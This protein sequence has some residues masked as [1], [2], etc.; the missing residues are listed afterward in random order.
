[1]VVASLVLVGTID[2]ELNDDRIQALARAVRRRRRA[3]D[4]AARQRDHVVGAAG[5]DERGRRPPGHR[6]EPRRL[7][8]NRPHRLGAAHRPA[9]RLH[10]PHRRKPRAFRIRARGDHGRD[11][12]GDRD[13]HDRAGKRRCD[14]RRAQPYRSGRSYSRLRR[15]PARSIEEGDA[16]GGAARAPV[17]RFHAPPAEQTGDSRARGHVSA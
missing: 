4:F 11:P 3:D 13:R 10:D 17:P 16:R 7:T 6:P 1:M 5:E 12:A 14:L 9:D 8:R 2:V 15:R